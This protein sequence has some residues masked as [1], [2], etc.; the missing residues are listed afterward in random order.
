MASGRSA[1]EKLEFVHPNF[2]DKG[3]LRPKE[4]AEVRWDHARS[5]QTY[6]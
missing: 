5:L 2:I 3:R 4:E 1:R 6:P